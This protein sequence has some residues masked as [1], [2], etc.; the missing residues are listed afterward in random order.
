MF[1]IINV[2]RLYV[3]KLLKAQWQYFK[4]KVKIT[5]KVLNYKSIMALPILA[6]EM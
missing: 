5:K 1:L 2:L 3:I 6:L 4:R